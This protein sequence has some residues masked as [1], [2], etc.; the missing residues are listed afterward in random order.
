MFEESWWEKAWL[1]VVVRASQMVFVD[2]LMESFGLIV[3]YG[4]SVGIY[5]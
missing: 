3:D 5:K 1:V 4:R 2:F